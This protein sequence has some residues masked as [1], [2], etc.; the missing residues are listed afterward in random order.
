MSTTM[1]RAALLAA[2]ALGVPTPAPAMPA[3]ALPAQIAAAAEEARLSSSAQV[4]GR[5]EALARDAAK[6]LE[7][8]DR[9]KAQ[10]LLA[11]ATRLLDNDNA[12][13]PRA[14]D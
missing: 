1:L 5:V 7:A 9:E 12:R 13:F 8:G 4:Q 6:A 2:T 14:G 10:A 3:H 11:R